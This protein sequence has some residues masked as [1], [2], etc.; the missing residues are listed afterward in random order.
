MLEKIIDILFPPKCFW[1]RKGPGYF[2]PECL[3]QCPPARHFYCIVCDKPADKGETHAGC[4]HFGTPASIFSPFEYKG[5]VR[6]C[7]LGAKY[8]ARA[9]AP[10][11]ILSETA[12]KSILTQ[13]L[14]FQGFIVVP[15]PLSIKRARERGFNQAGIIAKLLSFKLGLEYNGTIL[16]R[17]KETMAQHEKTRQE[18]FVN[19][20]GAFAVSTH[21]PGS[22]LLLVDD[23]CTTGATFLEASRVLYCAGAKEVRCFSLAKEF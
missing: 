19:M 5:V 20:S 6:A 22:K 7:I 17:S 2:C 18:R 12:A 1:C 15:I 21:P 8:K 14:D 23:I 11:K 16:M 3:S 13:E 4:R 10:L 9:F